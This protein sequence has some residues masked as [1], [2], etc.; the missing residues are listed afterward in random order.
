M[1]IEKEKLI[2]STDNDHMSKMKTTSY[3]KH[4]KS[5]SRANP[6]GVR[7]QNTLRYESS[8]KTL[9][10]ILQNP[11]DYKTITKRVGGGYSN[12]TYPTE[13]PTARK[14]KTMK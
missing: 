12:F 6:T 14:P 2:Q 3:K 8:P 13:E 5:L 9:S 7:K 10:N 1:V 11:D 4:S